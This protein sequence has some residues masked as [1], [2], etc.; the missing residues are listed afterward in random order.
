[1]LKSEAGKTLMYEENFFVETVLPKSIIRQLSKEEMEVFRAALTVRL[2]RKT[3]L[4]LAR[5]LPI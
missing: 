5:D 1:M 3:T 4:D 2:D